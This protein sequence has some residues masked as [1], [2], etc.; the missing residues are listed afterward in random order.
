MN[1]KLLKQM[2]LDRGETRR[3]VSLATG[4]TESSIQLY[5]TGKVNNPRLETIKALADHFGVTIDDLVV[6]KKEEATSA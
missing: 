4:L 5:E 2:R 1:S 3:A 6:E